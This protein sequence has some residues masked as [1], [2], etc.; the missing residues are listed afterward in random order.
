MNRVEFYKIE[1]E[2]E[3]NGYQR[4]YLLRDF[5]IRSYVHN[6]TCPNCDSLQLQAFVY[7]KPKQRRVVYAVCHH[8]DEVE[9]VEN[10]LTDT[11]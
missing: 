10:P 5:F 6:R 7:R 3:T 9:P 8:C 2:L 4:V 11:P 1:K